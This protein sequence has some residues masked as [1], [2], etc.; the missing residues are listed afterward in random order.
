M[1]TIKRCARC[2]EPM[3]GGPHETICFVCEIDETDVE[4]VRGEE[5]PGLAAKTTVAS[6]VVEPYSLQVDPIA[7]TPTPSPPPTPSNRSPAN[8]GVTTGGYIP[9]PKGGYKPIAG[10]LQTDRKG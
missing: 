9:T 2:R 5:N 7:D 8:S 6:P 1:K 4:E 10:G 3:G